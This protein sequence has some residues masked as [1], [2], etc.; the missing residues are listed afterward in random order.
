MA[1]FIPGPTLA[2]YTYQEEKEG[3]GGLISVEDAINTEERNINVYN[4]QSQ[5]RCVWL[6]QACT[7]RI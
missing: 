5:E 6:S 7:E 3:G 1:L 2:V 4:S